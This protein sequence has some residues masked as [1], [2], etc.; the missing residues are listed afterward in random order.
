MWRQEFVNTSR[1]RFEIFV[2]GAGRPLCITHLYTEFNEQG[3]YFADRFVEHYKVYLINLKEAGKSSKVIDDHELSMQNTVEDLEAVRGELQFEKW[4]YAG[5]S[6]GGMLGLV[7]AIEKPDSLTTFLVGGASATNKFMT[8]HGSMYSPTC[9]L[10][11]RL[12]ELLNIIQLPESTREVRKKAAREWTEMSLY[13][14]EH[15]DIYF[16]TPSS[17]KVINKR[18]NYFSEIELPTFNLLEDLPHVSIPA[19]IYCG[20][21]DAQC[22]LVFS[23]EIHKLLPNSHMVV[24]NESNH[25]PFL[26]EQTVFDE[27][28]KSFANREVH[29]EY[30]R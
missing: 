7:Y 28:V 29:G 21:H 19:I 2:K 15:F 18:L 23:E 1:G 5:H 25:V 8:H 14:P 3:Y 17:G 6:T 27:M 16:S 4:A 20:K 22:P 24:F 10:N 30:S 11:S 13:R 26:E 9:P 12:K